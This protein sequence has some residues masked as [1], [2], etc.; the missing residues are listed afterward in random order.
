MNKR[1]L[2][3]NFIKTGKVSDYLKYRKAE[4]EGFDLPDTEFA[5]EFYIDDPDPE[6]FRYDV[7]DR[8]YNNP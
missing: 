8:R 6:D 5:D 1:E 2:W 7:H 4:R 3:G